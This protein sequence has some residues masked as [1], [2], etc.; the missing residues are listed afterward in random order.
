[1]LKPDQLL[2]FAAGNITEPEAATMQAL[3]LRQIPVAEV[4]AD[5]RAAAERAVQWAQK[6]E[7]LLV[8]LDVDVLDYADFPIAENVRRGEGLSWRALEAALTSLLKAPNWRVLTIAEVNPDHA[9]DENEAFAQL[10]GALGRALSARDSLKGRAGGFAYGAVSTAGGRWMTR[11]AMNAAVVWQRGHAN[12][13]RASRA[14]HPASISTN[15][16]GHAAHCGH[17]CR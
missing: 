4:A 15:D 17:R 1:M 12:R 16:I 10:V 13:N 9:P 14:R 5:P 11:I 8:H 6:F 7:L 2:F 3:Q